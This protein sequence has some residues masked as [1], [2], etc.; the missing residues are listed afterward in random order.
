MDQDEEEEM[1][2]NV[3]STHKSHVATKSE[4]RTVEQELQEIEHKKEG[5]DRTVKKRK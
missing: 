1:V 2:L 5:I 4:G 3:A